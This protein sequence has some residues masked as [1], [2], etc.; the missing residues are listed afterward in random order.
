MEPPLEPRFA[1]D[2]DVADGGTVVVAADGELHMSTAPRLSAYLRSSLR[3]DTERL[4]VDL[5]GVH[6]I[7]ST[8]LGVL[9]STL[10]EVQRRGG[11]MAVVAA[12]PTVL[13][14]FA[15]TGTDRTL[16]VRP[17]RR[18][19]LSAVSGGDGAGPACAWPAHGDLLRGRPPRTCTAS[20]PRWRS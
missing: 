18:A 1:V 4:V 16:D 9:L 2:T 17:D 13:R 14:L 11:R 5:S 6:F 7:D 12:N 19:A 10:R 20:P 8:G 15:I 3:G